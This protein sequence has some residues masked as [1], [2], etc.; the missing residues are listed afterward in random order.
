MW[1]SVMPAGPNTEEPNYIPMR[2]SG[3]GEVSDTLATLG[4][5]ER[6]ICSYWDPVHYIMCVLFMRHGTSPHAVLTPK[7]TRYQPETYFIS[8]LNLPYTS[9]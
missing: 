7:P 2:S 9:P 8:A 3:L 4:I 5:W 6:N 1:S